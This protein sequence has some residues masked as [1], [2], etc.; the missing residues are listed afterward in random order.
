MARSTSRPPAWCGWRKSS[1]RRCGSPRGTTKIIPSPPPSPKGASLAAWSSSFLRPRPSAASNARC[2][3]AATS[4]LEDRFFAAGGGGLDFGH[5]ARILVEDGVE[6]LAGET[7]GAQ[8]VG[9]G[10][11]GGLGKVFDHREI[12]DVFAGAQ[13]DGRGIVALRKLELGLALADH[14]EGIDDLSFPGDE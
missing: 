3:N 12:A 1:W 6:G 2:A 7:H 5:R 11:A 9:R 8:T 10:H 4:N 14:P 13:R